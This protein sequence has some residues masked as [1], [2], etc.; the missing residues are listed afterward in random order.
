M[1]SAGCFDQGFATGQQ[2]MLPVAFAWRH[3][4]TRISA[5]PLAAEESSV[6]SISS[7]DNDQY[8]SRLLLSE[9][10]ASIARR[11]RTCCKVCRAFPVPENSSG[12]WES[13]GRRSPGTRRKLP[14]SRARRGTCGQSGQE[15]IPTWAFFII[16][17]RNRQ[18]PGSPESF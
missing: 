3:I 14:T 7:S 11:R 4:L 6:K 12:V 13:C 1:P 18:K 17:G 8:P 9:L 10:R 16:N 5:I 2:T 15:A